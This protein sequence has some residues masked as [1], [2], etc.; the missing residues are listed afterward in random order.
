[1]PPLGT[2]LPA[3]RAKKPPSCDH[4]KVSPKTL[5]TPNRRL[6][7]TASPTSSEQQKRVLCHPSPAG[8]PRCVEK[9]I[10]CTTTP[11]V[12]RKPT[13]RTNNDA[14]R[15]SATPSATVSPR[16]ATIE[17]LDLPVP[18]PL[19]TDP[20]TLTTSTAFARPI[21]STSSFVHDP[22]L[23]PPFD[24]FQLVSLH[25]PPPSLT[26]SPE[27]AHHLFKVFAQTPQHEH[28]VFATY[29][30]ERTLKTLGWRIEL[31]PSHS[32]VLAY[33]IF[34]VASLI[35][36]HPS[37]LDPYH[38]NF[39]GACPN[40][41][42]A[43]LEH[44][45]DLRQFGKLR[46]AAAK[47]YREEALR[48]AKE[49]DILFV[50]SEEA[51]TVCHLL[52]WL[53]AVSPGGNRSSCSVWHTAGINHIRV[54]SR[55]IS[56]STSDLQIRWACYMLVDSIMALLNAEAPPSASDQLYLIGPH[57]FT[58][59]AVD[60]DV[61]RLEKDST[62]GWPLA[63]PHLVLGLELCRR[64]S[65]EVEGSWSQDQ[66]FDFRKTSAILDSLESR[67]RC[68][69]QLIR[70][71]DPYIASISHSTPIHHFPNFSAR[72]PQTRYQTDQVTAMRSFRTILQLSWSHPTLVVYEKLRQRQTKWPTASPDITDDR[73]L[74]S[75]LDFCVA[76]ARQLALDGLE[77]TVDS[78]R[79]LASLAAWTHILPSGLERWARFILGDLTEGLVVMDS[80][81]ATTL[82]TL[83]SG[84][85]QSGYVWSN[86]SIDALVV[87]LDA[88]AL[89]FRLA[90]SSSAQ[91]RTTSGPTLFT[92]DRTS[93]SSQSFPAAP[94]G[95]HDFSSF[96]PTSLSLFANLTALSTP[97]ASDHS[98]H[99]HS[100]VTT[101]SATT[102]YAGG[103]PPAAAPASS[104]RCDPLLHHH[105]REFAGSNGLEELSHV[106]GLY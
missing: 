28:P 104:S 100:P 80:K 26:V 24:A 81:L 12:R 55:S 95:E 98:P 18:P 67:K 27:L 75:R 48:R 59:E 7:G 71:L 57:A 16:A 52:T 64:I 97:S 87:N 41:F 46:L 31:L 23:V 102:G 34:A 50:A 78:F 51:A 29:T 63:T 72:D 10:E 92:S 73:G 99:G 6:T 35:S 77:A 85:K 32:S 58:E 70:S 88:Q 68:A 20:A 5:A 2:K 90:S 76:E 86:P 8:C 106:L 84:L 105:G 83:S 49:S 103:P 39:G 13:R 17:P 3:N 93:S 89:A 62:E 15:P 25:A 44:L 9:G 96:D 45:P 40:S 54:L 65:A 101:T 22:L 53:E 66:P 61:Q 56:I 36:Y 21:A 19:T 82:E 4:C 94:S 38:L 11:V 42:A 91:P 60:R 74:K 33:C 30:L 14:H 43:V 1:M 37:I 79:R 69:A 47:G